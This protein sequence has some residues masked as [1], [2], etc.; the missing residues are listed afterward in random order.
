MCYVLGQLITHDHLTDLPEIL[1]E[2]FCRTKVMFL[3]EFV[4]SKF[5]AKLGSQAIE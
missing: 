4:N 1:I 2:E 5:K 3:A